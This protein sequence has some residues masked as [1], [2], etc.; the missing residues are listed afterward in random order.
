MFK[1]LIICVLLCSLAFCSEADC[2]IQSNPDGS[3]T[4][5]CKDLSGTCPSG[6]FLFDDSSCNQVCPSGFSARENAICAFPCGKNSALYPN[7][8]CLDTCIIGYTLRMEGNFMVC[9]KDTTSPTDDDDGLYS[10]TVEIY[11]RYDIPFK[12]FNAGDYLAKFVTM[13][14]K[15]LDV[16]SSDIKILSLKDGST[17]IE[18]EV[19]VKSKP[20]KDTTLKA[21]ALSQKL[22]DAVE[23][24]DLNLEGIGVLNHHFSVVFPEQEQTGTEN[25]NT[26]KKTPYALAIGLG[27]G[28]I[29]LLVIC[30]YQRKHKFFSVKKQNQ[31]PAKTAAETP[32]SAEKK[33]DDEIYSFVLH[34]SAS[35]E[36]DN[37]TPIPQRVQPPV[38]AK[39]KKDEELGSFV[40]LH[41]SVSRETDSLSP[42]PQRILPEAFKF[43]GTDLENNQLNPELK[44][45]RRKQTDEVGLCQEKERDIIEEK[46][47]A[48]EEAQVE[49]EGPLS[50]GD[51]LKNLDEL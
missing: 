40:V 24:K 6:Y 15:L 23:S 26:H 21:N 4:T 34:N 38:S 5:D 32:A 13:L 35:R 27:V 19:A 10:A 28:L 50:M 17:M 31:V 44:S 2:A 18:S 25:S 12:D 49:N 3:K 51:I 46:L 29:V 11:L 41:N 47:E 33:K 48:I 16:N 1:V 37:I 39:K 9:D 8:R 22:N 43:A 45:V 42:L 20:L 36:T 7:G 14:T 30:K